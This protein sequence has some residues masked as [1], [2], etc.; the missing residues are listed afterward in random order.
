MTRINPVLIELRKLMITDLADLVVLWNK[1]PQDY[2]KHFI[3]FEFTNNKLESILSNAV[4]DLY[5][6][7]FVNKKIAGFYMLRGFD[8]G[9]ETPSYGV[10]IS[11]SYSNK[12]LAKLTLQHAISTCLLTGANKIMLK[13]HTENTIALNLYKK[14][15]FKETGIDEKINN[16]IMHK[17]LV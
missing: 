1:D 6:G 5:I 17:D 2:N 4:K 14:Y 15:G 12:G 13:V 11:S 9:Y 10:W 8:E 3:P 16:I 7:I